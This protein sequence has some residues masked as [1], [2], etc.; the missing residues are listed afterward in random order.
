MGG[1]RY[2]GRRFVEWRAC[3]WGLRCARRGTDCRRC[4]AHENDFAD[5]VA[6][7]GVA[8]YAKFATDCLD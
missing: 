4:V 1:N 6:M 3:A 2:S 7:A 8:F 5:D